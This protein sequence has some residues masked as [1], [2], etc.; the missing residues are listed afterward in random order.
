[1]LLTFALDN[2]CLILY[3]FVSWKNERRWGSQCVVDWGQD[4]VSWGFVCWSEGEP[5]LNARPPLH[6]TYM[7]LL[8][9]K[10]TLPA[11]S[12]DPAHSGVRTTR[13][14]MFP[15][16]FELRE[17]QPEWRKCYLL[18]NSEN[19]TNIVLLY[20]TFQYYLC[21]L[22][23]SRIDDWMAANLRN[24]ATMSIKCPTANFTWAND[25]FDE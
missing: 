2:S 14:L 6:R 5:N 18:Y 12:L 19:I 15:H 25:I 20:Y 22:F 23:I 16:I 4:W 9:A 17:I 21:M 3:W 13:C 24:F 8:R 11:L 1:M 10:T 7:V